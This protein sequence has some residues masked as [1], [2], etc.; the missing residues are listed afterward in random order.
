MIVANNPSRDASRAFALNFFYMPNPY[1]TPTLPL[2]HVASA[3]LHARKAN[4]DGS[5]PSRC[6]TRFPVARP[7][8]NRRL[9]MQTTAFPVPC[10]RQAD[11]V[12]P[13]P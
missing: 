2:F 11:P 1:Q 5:K 3:N 12:R 8:A 4:R 9:R 6:K 7:D 10:S 13:I